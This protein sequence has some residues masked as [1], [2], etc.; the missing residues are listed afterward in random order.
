M[1]TKYT[2]DTKEREDEKKTEGRFGDGRKSGQT[3]RCGVFFCVSL[4]RVFSV[5]RGLSLLAGADFVPLGD[6][7]EC[8]LRVG[9]SILV[10]GSRIPIIYRMSS[11]GFTL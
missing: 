11:T 7:S 6:M 9:E 2:N 10:G 5:F 1:T 4:F 8:H 3:G